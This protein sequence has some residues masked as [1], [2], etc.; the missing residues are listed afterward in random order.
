ME[1]FTSYSSGFVDVGQLHAAL[2]DQNT[3]ESLSIHGQHC[4]SFERN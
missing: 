1:N 2:E 3:T 4:H